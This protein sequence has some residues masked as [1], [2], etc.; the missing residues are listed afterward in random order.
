MPC[1]LHSGVLGRTVPLGGSMGSEDAPC[2]LPHRASDAAGAACGGSVPSGSLCGRHGG[3]AAGGAAEPTR[4]PVRGR[5]PGLP[6][7]MYGVL[8]DFCSERGL[9]MGLDGFRPYNSITR[10]AFFSK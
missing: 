1:G 10:C 7:G 5:R 2:T 8:T 3:A 9:S 4:P 6:I